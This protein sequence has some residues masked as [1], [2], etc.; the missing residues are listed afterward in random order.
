MYSSLIL[1]HSNKSM[2]CSNK[3]MFR[4][5]ES[6]QLSGLFLC[7]SNNSSTIL[8]HLL[9]DTQMIVPRAISLQRS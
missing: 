4:S 5:N 8:L 1:L 2:L 3:P 6:T 7:P 9:N